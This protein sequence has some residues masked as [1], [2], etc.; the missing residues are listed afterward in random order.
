MNLEL[1]ILGGYGPFV[2][3]AYI[4]TFTICYAFYLK[5]RREF[6]KQEKIFLL[7]ENLGL[8]NQNMQ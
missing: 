6:K 7:M 1:L 3:P 2:W 5:I 8:K 4:F